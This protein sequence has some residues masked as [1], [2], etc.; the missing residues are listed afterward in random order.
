M[1]KTSFK[2]DG[3]FI[4]YKYMNYLDLFSQFKAQKMIMGS[5]YYKRFRMTQK[6]AKIEFNKIL[7]K[8]NKRMTDD[9]ILGAK[10]DFVNYEIEMIKQRTSKRTP[11]VF[12]N[13]LYIPVIRYNKGMKKI[14]RCLHDI[15]PTVDFN[16]KIRKAYQNNIYENL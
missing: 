12:N 6:A 7:A 3:K 4:E 5:S 11:T 14:R 8:F 10:V 16:I 13:H 1:R 2:K 9:I 15:K